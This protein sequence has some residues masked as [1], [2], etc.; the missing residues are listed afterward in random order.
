M[1]N[2]ASLI[3]SLL[4]IIIA[5]VIGICLWIFS[6]NYRTKNWGGKMDIK[7]PENTKLIN[8]SWKNADLWILIED[9][10]THEMKMLEN[11]T[12]GVFEGQITFKNK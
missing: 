7:L 5:I 8:A 4:G 9:T 12:Y 6:A 1:K 3:G 11:S 10:T 2:N